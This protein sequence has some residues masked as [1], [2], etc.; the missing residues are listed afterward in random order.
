MLF[1]LLRRKKRKYYNLI[2]YKID[3]KA[4]LSEA[5]T[6]AKKSEM[7]LKPNLAR[8][9]SMEGQSQKQD[10]T[11]LKDKKLLDNIENEVKKLQVRLTLD[12]FFFFF[13]L[14]FG[15]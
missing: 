3:L 7:E 9:R 8:I 14:N 5:V 13:F 1:L 4:Q 2:I 11:Y 15:L 6:T 10:G 12:F